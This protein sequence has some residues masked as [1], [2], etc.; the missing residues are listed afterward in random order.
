MAA[1]NKLSQAS[2][3]VPSIE[4]SS[5]YIAWV[6]DNEAREIAAD[7]H[8][9]I[10]YLPFRYLGVPLSTKKLNYNQCKI[11]VGENQ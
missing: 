1:F 5:V 7:V 6:L 9:P 10:G 8:L 3:L 2:S 4:K 11:L